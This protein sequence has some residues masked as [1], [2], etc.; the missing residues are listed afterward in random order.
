MVFNK[1]QRLYFTDLGLV[2]QN[3]VDDLQVHV[4]LL[5]SELQVERL[6]RFDYLFGHSHSVDRVLAER[7]LNPGPLVLLSDRMVLGQHQV[8]IRVAD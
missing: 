4:H 1:G 6:H 2:S 5:H 3:E 8:V 7:L